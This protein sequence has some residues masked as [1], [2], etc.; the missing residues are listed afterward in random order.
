MIGFYANHSLKMSKNRKI[1]SFFVRPGTS[2]SPSVSSEQTSTESEDLTI[3]ESQ[4]F[5]ANEP[6]D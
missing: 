2:N 5:T 4:N 6:K 3:E 1:D